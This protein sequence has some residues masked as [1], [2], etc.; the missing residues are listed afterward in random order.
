MNIQR[1]Y[2]IGWR[3][4]ISLETRQNEFIYTYSIGCEEVLR[5]KCNLSEKMMILEKMKEIEILNGGYEIIKGVVIDIDDNGTRWE[6]DAL[7]GKAFGYGC[8]YNENNQMI[9]SGFVYE[10]KYFCYGEEFY[11][12][13]NTIE[14][15]GNYMNGLRHGYGCC[16]DKEGNLVYEG[17]WLFGRNESLVSRIP[18]DGVNDETINNLISEL[19]IGNNSFADLNG[20]RLESYPNLK[21][22]EIGDDS[23]ANA[24]SFEISNCNELESLVIGNKAFYISMKDDQGSFIIQDCSKLSLIK[25]GHVSFANYQDQFLLYSTLLLIFII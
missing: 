19:L 24:F 2:T 23:F 21:T 9:Y 25:I 16:Y 10:G 11:C 6:G 14:Y 12:D 4:P 20:F 5:V 17:Y 7:N 22:I 3:K 8:F 15:R 1:H 13:T 18:D